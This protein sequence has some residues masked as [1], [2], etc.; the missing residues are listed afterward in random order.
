VEQVLDVGF[1][2]A[3]V[4]V[5]DISGDGRTE[6]KVTMICSTGGKSWDVLYRIDSDGAKLV[7]IPY[8]E[9]ELEPI[10]GGLPFSIIVQGA[11]T[12]GVSTS[13][14]TCTPT[15]AED[16]RQEIHWRLDKSGSWILRPDAPAEPGCPSYT[17]EGPL[18]LKLCDRGGGV[19][20]VQQVLAD[21]G[22]DVTP[23]E[24]YGPTT[25]SAVMAFQ[26]DAG[27]T[28]DGVVGPATWD[29]LG[30]N[31]ETNLVSRMELIPD[32]QRWVDTLPPGATDGYCESGVAPYD[33][34]DANGGVS[35]GI[36]PVG[37]N[38]VND[39]ALDELLCG[40]YSD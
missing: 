12:S 2:D 17:F 21:R 38:E 34:I 23:D 5:G 3:P 25:K 1:P 10:L 16:Q 26:Q 35:D 27:L 18:P 7:E 39:R 28:V 13:V 31:N 9:N 11:D 14:G 20:W 15:C 29:A 19:W 40:P 4:M 24:Q 37:L 32:A 6:I 8:A 30:G 22:Y 36:D 33:F